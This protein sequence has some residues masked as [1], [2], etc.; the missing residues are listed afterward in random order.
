MPHLP[1]EDDFLFY[2]FP[3]SYSYSRAPLGSWPLRHQCLAQ[4]PSRAVHH[5]Q[6]SEGEVSQPRSA[7]STVCL[8]HP[9]RKD[10]KKALWDTP[11]AQ[12][13]P[14]PL[15]EAIDLCDVIISDLVNV[16]LFLIWIL[17]SALFMLIL[18][19]MKSSNL[20][21]DTDLLIALIW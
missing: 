11:W 18:L 15:C 6:P 20:I 19:D 7:V 17:Y 16:V 10:E 9:C 2:F 12:A 3:L 5:C 1:Q 14:L 13:G 4:L 8:S 21:N